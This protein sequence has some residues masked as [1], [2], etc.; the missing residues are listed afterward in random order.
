MKRSSLLVILQLASCEEKVSTKG[1]LH[2]KTQH[3]HSILTSLTR[4]LAPRQILR[5]S[6]PLICLPF[7]DRCFVCLSEGIFGEAILANTLKRMQAEAWVF[8][9]VIRTAWLPLVSF[10][11]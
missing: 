2:L 3:K 1:R 5:A 11:L 9:L 6:L 4:S 8:E 10:K 7:R